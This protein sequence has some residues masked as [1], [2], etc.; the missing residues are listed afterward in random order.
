MMISQS[1]CSDW[2]L[3]PKPENN[4]L[5]VTLLIKAPYKVLHW[6]RVLILI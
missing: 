3:L 4:D 6:G 5:N 2:E 1:L